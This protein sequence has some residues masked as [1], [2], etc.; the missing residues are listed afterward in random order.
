VTFTNASGTVIDPSGSVTLG[1]DLS[2]SNNKTLLIFG[3]GIAYPFGKAYFIDVGYRFGGILSKVSD[4]END[5]TIK[6]QRI[7]LGAGVRF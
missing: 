5:Q 2:G 3:G 4:I 7:M 1:G 6:T